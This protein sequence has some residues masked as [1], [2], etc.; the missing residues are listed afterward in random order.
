MTEGC[1]E[2]HGYQVGLFTIRDWAMKKTLNLRIQY[3]TLE[4]RDNAHT[5]SIDY[6][7]TTF[8]IFVIDARHVPTRSSS[9]GQSGS[10]QIANNLNRI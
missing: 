10:Q 9:F 3:T 2:I 8:T 7:I 6:A 4:I 5:V 1:T